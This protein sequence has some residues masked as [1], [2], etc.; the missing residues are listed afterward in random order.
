M[1]ITNVLTKQGQFYPVVSLQ[2]NTVTIRQFEK[3]G[4]RYYDTSRQI[5]ISDVKEVFINK[6]SGYWKTI[7]TNHEGRR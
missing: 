5:P 7:H 3:S 1:I 4:A 2:K 6:G